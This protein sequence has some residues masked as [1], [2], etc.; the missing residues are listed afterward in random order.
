IRGADVAKAWKHGYV[1]VT[2]IKNNDNVGMYFCR[3][4]GQNE[5]LDKEKKS[6]RLDYYPPYSKIYTSS[7]NM[8]H[9]TLLHLNSEEIA[10]IVG[11]R[12]PC[13]EQSYSIRL[14]DTDEEVNLIGHIT[15]NDKRNPYS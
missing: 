15:Y 13:Y 8:K 2:K 3:L 6:G 4:L 5:L 9:P 10:N 1:K 7:K 14:C 11:D 12:I